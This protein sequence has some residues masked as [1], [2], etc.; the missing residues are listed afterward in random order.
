[1]VSIT[2]PL[3]M[4]RLEVLRFEWDAFTW[5]N[6]LASCSDNCKLRALVWSNFRLELV[7]AFVD[8]DCELRLRYQIGALK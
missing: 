3:D 7:N 6:Q 8:V 2:K 4:V 5:W 1:M